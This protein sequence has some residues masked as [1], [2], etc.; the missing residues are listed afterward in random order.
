MFLACFVA[1]AAA[2]A[3]YFVALLLNYV[4]QARAA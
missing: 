4:W 1:F 3:I 2:T